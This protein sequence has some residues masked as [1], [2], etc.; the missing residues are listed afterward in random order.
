MSLAVIFQTLL[1][2]GGDQVWGLWGLGQQSWSSDFA[3]YRKYY[4]IL[5]ILDCHDLKLGQ[6]DSDLYFCFI[7]FA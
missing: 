1:E 3:L 2:G 7:D 6:G 4:L 5:R